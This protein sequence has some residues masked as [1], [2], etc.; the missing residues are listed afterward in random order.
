MVGLLYSSVRPL[1]DVKVFRVLRNATN[2][3][4]AGLSVLLIPIDPSETLRVFTDNL[5]WSLIFLFLTL[6]RRVGDE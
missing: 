5:E 1:V 4:K 2:N 3:S 6:A